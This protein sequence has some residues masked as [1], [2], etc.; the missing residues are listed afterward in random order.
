MNSNRTDDPG[1]NKTTYFALDNIDLY[2][3]NCEGNQDTINYKDVI[4]EMFR[5]IGTLTY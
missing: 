5:C 4:T 3:R 1:F 2:N